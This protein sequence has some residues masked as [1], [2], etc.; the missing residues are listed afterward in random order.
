M[1]KRSVAALISKYLKKHH[2]IKIVDQVLN[3]MRYMEDKYKDAKDFLHAID[4]GLSKEDEKMAISTINEK[5][6][7]KCLFMTLSTQS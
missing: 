3:K 1:S 2:V 4:E 6:D 5:V 7:Q